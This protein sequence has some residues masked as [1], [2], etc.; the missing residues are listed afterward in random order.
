MN[1]R[2]QH[3][4]W[5]KYLKSW[6]TNEQ[7]YCLMTNRIF[8]TN[9]HGIANIRD[10]YSFKPLEA[11][12][13]ELIKNMFI[14]NNSP[15]LKKINEKWL[16]IF[17]LTNLVQKINNCCGSIKEINDALINFGE[18]IH[19]K[20]ESDSLKYLNQLLS[21][22]TDFYN[23]DEDYF[24]F[25]FFISAQFVRTNRNKQIILQKMRKNDDIDFEN[26]WNVCNYIIATNMAFGLHS[27]KNKFKI[28]K[29]INNTDVSFITGDQPVINTYAAMNLE[30]ELIN[31]IELYYPITPKM[32]ILIT[33]NDKYR[34][35]KVIECD[36]N[37]VNQFNSY[38]KYYSFEQLYANNS[39]D[40]ECYISIN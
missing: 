40:L 12:D 20:I 26:I 33:Q 25:N 11:K 14:I 36:A 5:R 3:F 19:T 27:Y 6:S 29:I 39:K 37:I 8:K 28:L 16:E 18:K 30:Q 4:V 9:L 31:D 1:T 24:N 7:L 23:Q 10:F 34:T 15:E 38:I 17:Q 32:S 13:F 21:G 35:T 22:N 2:K